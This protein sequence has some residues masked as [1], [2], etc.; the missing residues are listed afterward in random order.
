VFEFSLLL[1]LTC[2]QIEGKVNSK[3]NK[4]TN[5]M[6]KGQT[7]TKVKF[8]QMACAM[9]I[10]VLAFGCSKESETPT[11]L[12]KR[13]TLDLL[14][15]L[16]LDD[17]V[18]NPMGPG[19]YEWTGGT[20]SQ[21]YDVPFVITRNTDN[22]GLEPVGFALMEYN[23]VDLDFDD[24]SFCES[25]N[26]VSTQWIIR[27]GGEVVK[28][29]TGSSATVE[30]STNPTGEQLDITQDYVVAVKI[31][32]AK[33]GAFCGFFDTDI[34]FCMPLNGCIESSPVEVGEIDENGDFV[35]PGYPATCSCPLDIA[36]GGTVAAVIIPQAYMTSGN[37]RP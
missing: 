33:D 18:T 20:P 1:L 7:I 9:M 22:A 11:V 23:V 26:I 34:E 3:T 5:K 6:K 21:S 29:I 8:L 24:Q 16:E 14:V 35:D 36:P 17:G 30:L 37:Q 4:Q 13:Q 12:T 31:V 19:D 25:G 32:W 28:T 10:L 27:S 2:N 15:A